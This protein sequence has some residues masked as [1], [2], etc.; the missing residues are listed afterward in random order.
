M[1]VA[2]VMAPG[3]RRAGTDPSARGCGALAGSAAGGGGAA[4]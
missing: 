1:I 2:V 4:R 3:T